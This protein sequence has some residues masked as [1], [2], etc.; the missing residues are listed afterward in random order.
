VISRKALRDFS[1]G[2]IDAAKQVILTR[3]STQV[4]GWHAWISPLNRFVP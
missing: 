4:A 2:S 1:T 3:H